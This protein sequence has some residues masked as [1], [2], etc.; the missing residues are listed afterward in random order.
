MKG[1][2]NGPHRIKKHV[3][4]T[5]CLPAKLPQNQLPLHKISLYC[6]VF[7]V[8]KPVSER[9]LIPALIRFLTKA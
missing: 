8:L 7:Y 6:R 5:C 9:A 4:V 2:S 3:N 1:E